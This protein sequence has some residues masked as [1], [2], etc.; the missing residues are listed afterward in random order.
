MSE[1]K[2]GVFIT[3]V[4][5]GEM[6]LSVSAVTLD[7]AGKHHSYAIRLPAIGFE[8]L[9]PGDPEMSRL[10]NEEAQPKE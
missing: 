2:L 10:L 4:P 1:T 8:N 3:R 9:S 6:V 7:A 5:D